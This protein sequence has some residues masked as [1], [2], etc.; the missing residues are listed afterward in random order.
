MPVNQTTPHNITWDEFDVSSDVTLTGRTA[1]GGGTWTAGS[2]TFNIL[3]ATD[4]A[5]SIS[6]AAGGVIAYV[7]DN[8]PYGM[9]SADGII[10][11][12]DITA[13]TTVNAFAGVISRFSTTSALVCARLVMKAGG[14]VSIALSY[15]N[16][17]AFTDVQTVDL[18][19]YDPSH[20]F[21]V[22]LETYTGN[23]A[24]S[25]PGSAYVYVDNKLVISEPST[26]ISAFRTALAVIGYSGLLASNTE[27]TFDNFQSILTPYSMVK[28][29]ENFNQPAG[30]GLV[31]DLGWSFFT[32]NPTNNVS[33]QAVVGSASRLTINQGPGSPPSIDVGRWYKDVGASEMWAE[34]DVYSSAALALWPILIRTS[35]TDTFSVGVYKQGA[36]VLGFGYSGV[37]F[38]TASVTFPIRIR[39]EARGNNFR[40]MYRAIGSSANWTYFGGA[41]TGALGYSLPQATIDARPTLLT[42]TLVGLGYH[43]NSTSTD[44]LDNFASGPLQS[45]IV[46]SDSISTTRADVIQLLPNDSEF[47]HAE[48]TESF[49][50]QNGKSLTLFGFD[51]NYGTGYAYAS[52]GIGLNG[53]SGL[54]LQYSSV[55]STQFY[56]GTNR[57]YVIGSTDVG[58]SSWTTTAVTTTDNTTIVFPDG[59]TDGNNLAFGGSATAQTRVSLPSIVSGTTYTYSIWLATTTGTVNITLGYGTSTALTTS[60]QVVSVTTT[61]TRFSL[62]F[63]AGSSTGFVGLLNG[64][65]TVKTVVAWGAQVEVGSTPGE[66]FSTYTTVANIRPTIWTKPTSTPDHYVECDLVNVVDVPT[67]RPMPLV[68]RA[69]NSA[70]FVGV[71]LTGSDLRTVNVYSPNYIPLTAIGTLPSY[72]CRIRAQI[73]NGQLLVSYGPSGVRDPKN[74]LGAGYLLPTTMYSGFDTAVNT[75]FGI[76]TPSS[77]GTADIS[78]I[79]DD[80]ESGEIIGADRFVVLPAKATSSSSADRGRLPPLDNQFSDVEWFENF[81]DDDTKSLIDFGFTKESMYGYMYESG[82]TTVLVNQNNATVDNVLY[83]NRSYSS[84][85]INNLTAFGGATLGTSSVEAYDGS[86]NNRTITFVSG[87]LSGGYQNAVSTSIVNPPSGVTDLTLSCW[88]WTTSG[89]TT[90]R[91]SSASSGTGTVSNDIVVTTT[92]TR[93]SVTLPNISSLTFT[94]ILNGSG[95][96]G[97]SVV[98]RGYQVEYGSVATELRGREVGAPASRTPMMWTQPVSSPDQYV[99]FDLPQLSGGIN[100]PTTTYIPAFLRVVNSYKYLG[101]QLSGRYQ[102]VLSIVSSSGLNQL[103]GSVTNS[104]SR[105]RV[106]IRGS[107]IWIWIGP[108]GTRSPTQLL[109]PPITVS[110]SL[111]DGFMTATKTGFGSA[112]N[113]TTLALTS[114]FDTYESGAALGG[115]RIGPSD[116]I[117]STKTETVFPVSGKY[118]PTWKDDFSSYAIGS[119]LADL[120]YEKLNGTG[121][122]EIGTLNALNVTGTVTASQDINRL[123]NSVSLFNQASW[124]TLN[125]ATKVRLNPDVMMP[126]GTFNGTEVSLSGNTAAVRGTLNYSSTN[127][128]YYQVSAVVSTVSGS[129]YVRLGIGFNAGAGISLTATDAPNISTDFYI[130]QTPRRITF[131]TPALIAGSGSNN[132]FYLYNGTDGISRNIIVWGPTASVSTTQFTNTVEYITRYS[133]ISDALP[134]LWVKE[135]G[136]TN[137]Y[138]ECDITNITADATI[139]KVMPMVLRAAN[140]SNF[141]GITLSGTGLL[142]VNA[143]VPG[144]M[145]ET[146]IGTLPSRPVRMRAEMVNNVLYV[147]YGPSGTAYPTTLLGQVSVDFSTKPQ[148]ATNRKAGFGVIPVT[149]GI[150]T[151]SGLTDNYD[152]GDVVDDSISMSPAVGRSQTTAD[153][154]RTRPSDTTYSKVDWSDNF[155]DPDT[156][157]SLT[158]FGFTKKSTYGYATARFGVTG[159]TTGGTLGMRYDNIANSSNGNFNRYARS[160]SLLGVTLIGSATRSTTTAVEFFDGSTNNVSLTFSS[161]TA[162]SGVRMSNY[163]NTTAGTTVTVSAW[164][165][166]TSGTSV[167]RLV[168]GAEGSATTS[169]DFTVTTTPTRISYTANALVTGAAW[170]I[171]NGSGN[172]G[173][174]IAVRGLQYERDGV[175]SEIVANETETAYLTSAL[176]VKPVSSTSQYVECDLVNLGSA[177]NNIIDYVPIAL[178]A[179]NAMKYVGVR[180]T[181]TDYKTI[182]VYSPAGLDVLAGVLPDYPCRIRAEIHENRFQIWIGPSG[183][184]EP[185]NLWFSTTIN[186]ALYP[187]FLTATNTGMGFVP[188][189]TNVLR[190]FDGISDTYESGEAPIERVLVDAIRAVSET[191]ADLAKLLPGDTYNS[192]VDWYEN[193]NGYATRTSLVDVGFEKV[194]GSGFAYTDSTGSVSHQDWQYRSTIED[195]ALSINRL[196]ISSM[197]SWILSGSATRTGTSSV[198]KFFEGTYNGIKVN[199]SSGTGNSGIRQRSGYQSFTN[200][201]LLTFSV[202]LATETGTTQVR[203]VATNTTG[204]PY[205]TSADMTVTTTP[206]RF[207]FTFTMAS[208][209]YVDVGVYSGSGNN[210]GSIV[211][212]GGQLVT[213]NSPKELVITDSLSSTGDLRTGVWVQNVSHPDQY[214][215]CDV[216]KFGYLNSS[217][218]QY[219]PAMLRVVDATKFV[220]IMLPAASGDNQPVYVYT[221]TNGSYLLGYIPKSALPGRIRIEIRG[222]KVYGFYGQ[223]G[224]RDPQKQINTNPLSLPEALY[225][226]FMTATKTGVGTTR[227]TANQNISQSQIAD[228]YESGA[229]IG[230]PR[231]YLTASDASST[232]R[233]DIVKPVDV[234]WYELFNGPAETPLVNLGFEYKTDEETGEP[235]NAVIGTQNRLTL[236]SS[237]NAAASWTKS[238]APAQNQFIQSD[239]YVPPYDDQYFM[240]LRATDQNNFIGMRHEL[241]TGNMILGYKV[242]GV[243]YV[244]YSGPTPTLPAAVRIEVVLNEIKAFTGPVGGEY[245]GKATTPFGLAAG[246]RFNQSTYNILMTGENSGVAR[247]NSTQSA[248]ILDNYMSGEVIILPVALTPNDASSITRADLAPV[249]MLNNPQPNK[250]VSET[251]ADEPTLFVIPP[252]TLDVDDAFS[253]TSADVGRMSQENL[254]QPDVG[255]S[256]T[257][258]DMPQVI[259]SVLVDGFKA[260][261][262]T[263]ADTAERDTVYA[264]GFKTRSITRAD[265]PYVQMANLVTPIGAVSQTRA[266]SGPI[267]GDPGTTV[268]RAISA[269]LADE[270]FVVM[271]PII[272]V[273]RAM[274][275]TLADATTINPST[276]TAR[277]W[278]FT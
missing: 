240:I 138:V 148:L 247:S 87:T 180:I 219:L 59:Y 162:N 209:V 249:S 151:I 70:S 7:V 12:A 218:T 67:V 35:N 276:Y 185:S 76:Y 217:T 58:G 50:Y 177:T 4:K 62:T 32:A 129:G 208:G 196:N 169:Q 226:E 221:W 214:I 27:P 22:T 125:T 174:T 11:T 21:N 267:N 234:I 154:A 5:V 99:E 51:K 96:N 230:P 211:G 183:I 61:P 131:N 179:V 245:G 176:W 54:S 109:C 243:D 82:G 101:I 259:M 263:L 195:N 258:A 241:S 236:K 225:P 238:L 55:Y 244:L 270:P 23:G 88:M 81:N 160:N 85:L 205:A 213:G 42:S 74:I 222:N 146:L 19:V 37:D 242:N 200:G 46:A 147:Y 143:Y 33:T 212:W 31:A 123:N 140:A 26:A 18:G 41:S 261:S 145:I 112:A 57:N 187:E 150:S 28:V 53:V 216:L 43:I 260:S 262:Q 235:L 97:G 127:D 30:T 231:V 202:W 47:N 29:D 15:K 17:T 78:N 130:D 39:V 89:T 254:P 111:Y 115:T 164:V 139:T 14:V 98:V 71:V 170:C 107:T 199:F 72:P 73:A 65:A 114:Y 68:L 149:T 64:S 265:R 92:P 93:Y 192:K 152:L 224:L 252:I 251:R 173:G 194:S 248:N 117:S 269:T 233:A 44:A 120:G 186:N 63:T 274:S 121:L 40:A 132:F 135:V 175:L 158:E 272:D 118:G 232:T 168:I 161:G 84:S 49:D 100:N 255:V 157:K 204:I 45:L 52:D 171:I 2:G 126:D 34:V 13:P 227:A 250:A 155:A 193:F 273:D 246:Y 86:T 95:L 94:S 113:D 239:L 237:N 110:S 166:S 119:S 75:G 48:W 69:L 182:R 105:M 191:R 256:N 184:R 278:I 201:Q 197:S 90:V 253:N 163:D 198:V 56:P 10:T 178:R 102:R 228:E 264:N 103:V 25:K 108:I 172:N 153:Y 8:N 207:S 206:Q 190:Q 137:Q 203:L 6:S 257:T 36:S 277:P 156:N 141:I 77:T 106:E 24:A 20:V 210:G 165:A 66:F 91:F 188:I 275:T 220:G 133:N 266:D 1:P 80:Y 124:T 116:A 9:K 167:V 16:S 159:D 134:G 122:Y 128:R 38:V 83:P 229:V 223:I 60:Q 271:N 3:S 181:G 104:A 79:M 268:D 142:D 189:S 136:R 144:V 215:E